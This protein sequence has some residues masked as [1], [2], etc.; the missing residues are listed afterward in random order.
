MEE[1][2]DVIEEKLCGILFGRIWLWEAL[3]IAT[4]CSITLPLP[5]SLSMARR[6]ISRLRA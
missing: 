3:A 2:G 5:A 1:S 6:C 4:A